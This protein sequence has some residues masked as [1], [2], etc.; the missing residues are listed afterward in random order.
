MI[1]NNPTLNAIFQEFHLASSI[2]DTIHKKQ[3]SLSLE[4]SD[5]NSKLERGTRIQLTQVLL[6]ELEKERDV[7]IKQA[8]YHYKLF[9][10]GK[11]PDVTSYP[12]LSRHKPE[13]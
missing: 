3:L 7:I 11:L 10:E 2:H 1:K 12:E 8:I 9:Q 4:L 5:P 6:L 13:V